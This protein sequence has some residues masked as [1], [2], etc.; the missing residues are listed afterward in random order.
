M[1]ELEREKVYLARHNY[2]AGGLYRNFG[3]PKDRNQHCE[4]REDQKHDECQGTGRHGPFHFHIT[5]K[6]N[7]SFLPVVC[8]RRST[9]Y[10]STVLPCMYVRLNALVKKY[11]GN[12]ASNY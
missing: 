12:D 4:R 10:L 5:I 8:P 9:R 7:C 6:L 2:Q 11:G 1:R 3:P